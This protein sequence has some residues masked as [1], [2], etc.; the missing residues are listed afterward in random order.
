[1]GIVVSAAASLRVIGPTPGSVAHS[2]KRAARMP[3]GLTTAMNK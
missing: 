1:M 3:N 2:G